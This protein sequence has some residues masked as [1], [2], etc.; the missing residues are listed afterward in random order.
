[1][2]RILCEHPFERA[3]D[4][5]G[6]RLRRA[7]RHPQIPRPEVH[8][9]VREEGR[10]LEIVRILPRDVAHCVGVGA[11]ER[12]AFRHWIGGVA[13]RDRGDQRLFHRPAV[14]GR[15]L[16]TLDRRQRT[17]LALGVRRTVVVAIDM[18]P[19]SRSFIGAALRGRGR[20]W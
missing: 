5:V 6:P 19:A 7:V 4:L 18:R 8:H 3:D 14:A 11:V 15:R 17:L 16:R 2:I 13:L 20:P 10:G 12:V 1:V 9:R